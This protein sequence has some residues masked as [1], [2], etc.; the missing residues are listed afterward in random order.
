MFP[1][2]FN[3]LSYTAYL[4]TSGQNEEFL[5]VLSQLSFDIRNNADEK[6]SILIGL[7]SNQSNK[8]SRRRTDAMLKFKLQFS[9]GSV[10]L[11]DIPT[12]HHNNQSSVSQIDHILFY[13]PTNSEVKMSF[14]KHLCKLDNF[15]NLSSHDALIGKM[16]L[17]VS[18]ESEL[19]PDY[20][21]TYIPSGMNQVWQV[22]KDNLLMYC[23][24]WQ[25][26][27][28]VQMKSLSYQNYFQKCQKFQ[29]RRILKLLHLAQRNVNKVNLSSQQNIKWLIKNL[30]MFVRNGGSTADQKR[31]TNQL[32]LRNLHPSVNYRKLRVKMSR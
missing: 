18:S 17:P 11:S 29:Q 24:V 21:S 9:L 16:I 19:E 12:F 30:K 25:I 22:I 13:I 20:S 15:A 23:K 7:D 14:H 2:F 8:S 32:G 28:T 3:I 10:L 1:D 26:N 5:E 31:L 6:S 27:L 4:P